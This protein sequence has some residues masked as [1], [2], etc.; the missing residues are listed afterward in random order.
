MKKAQMSNDNEATSLYDKLKGRLGGMLTYVF[1]ARGWIRPSRKEKDNYYL[2][3]K[4]KKAL[5]RK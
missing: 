3:S 1:L 5:D 4:G 2:T